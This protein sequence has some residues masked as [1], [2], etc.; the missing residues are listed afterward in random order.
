MKYKM[1]F[2]SLFMVISNQKLIAEPETISKTLQASIYKGEDKE[3]RT[4]LD[5]NKENIKARNYRW[6]TPLILASLEW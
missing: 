1:L 2:L 3:L 6:Q 4:F 5:R